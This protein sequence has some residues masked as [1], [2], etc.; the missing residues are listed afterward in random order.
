[1]RIVIL[2]NGNL[3]QAIEA[4]CIR[5]SIKFIKFYRK[6]VDSILS[7]IKPL[8]IVFNAEGYGSIP[9]CDLNPYEAYNTH[10]MRNIRLIT[11]CNKLNIKVI[12]FS[13]NYHDFKSNYS[14]SKK[15]MEEFVLNT[16][17]NS[18]IR[19]ANLYG[20]Y[21]P[22]NSLPTKLINAVREGS[23]KFSSNAIYPTDCDWLTKQIFDNLD[24]ILEINEE[25]IS[26]VPRGTTS[27][28]Y[29][30]EKL[31]NIPIKSYIDKDRPF[32]P[33]LI[34]TL[35]ITDDIFEVW[36]KSVLKQKVFTDEVFLC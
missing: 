19:V 2:G 15:A 22:E 18:V 30:V 36:D 25:A 13:T 6:P 8:D 21:R 24:S 29:F 35:P 31:Y 12:C 32:N 10:L 1:M 16:K 34:N 28:Y 23:R 26:I 3:A 20:Q 4:R 14:N 9:Q 17:K 5:D 11:E 33:F 7:E 27:A